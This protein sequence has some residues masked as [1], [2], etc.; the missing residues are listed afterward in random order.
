MGPEERG[1]RGTGSL[2]LHVPCQTPSQLVARQATRGLAGL[3]APGELE[4]LVLLL[5]ELVSNA[6]R[7]SGMSP[8]ELIEVSVEITP[9][10]IRASV[11]DG[12]PGLVDELSNSNNGYGLKILERLASQWGKDPDDPAHLWFEL[13]R[14]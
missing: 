6:I 13:K 4:D 12:G 8:E 3:L 10:V 1:N 9:E 5:N 7:H 14:A 2:Q 11:V